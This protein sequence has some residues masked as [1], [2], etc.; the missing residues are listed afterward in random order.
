MYVLTITTHTMDSSTYVQYISIIVLCR[1]SLFL[2]VGWLALFFERFETQPLY[3]HNFVF[4]FC[5]LSQPINV[6]NIHDESQISVRY[7]VCLSVDLL[8]SSIHHWAH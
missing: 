4:R 3:D 7:F 6:V 8:I 2:I 5:F 1:S